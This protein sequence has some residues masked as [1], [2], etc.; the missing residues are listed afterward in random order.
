M[1]AAKAS[2]A[3][4]K[5]GRFWDYHD[6]LFANQK[7]LD[8]ASLKKFATELGL[9]MAQ[10]E[11]DL[12]DPAILKRIEADQSAAVKLGAKGTPAFFVNGNYV[13]GA[14]PFEEFKKIIDAEI[15]KVDAQIAKGAD[16]ENAVYAVTQA[17]SK[18]AFDLLIRNVPVTKPP[19]AP[20]EI[21]KVSLR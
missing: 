2:M 11:K 16:P 1:I 15:G 3:A 21:W 13:K 9:D 17:N 14:K 10:F 6:T 18:E 4:H 5:Q 8:E 7:S 19:P 12:K 20:P